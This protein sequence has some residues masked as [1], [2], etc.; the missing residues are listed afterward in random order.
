MPSLSMLQ[1][2]TI[3]IYALIYTDTYV[4][5]FVS[6]LRHQ[7]VVLAIWD[8]SLFGSHQSLFKEYVNSI[9]LYKLIFT[10]DKI[11]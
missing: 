3:H 7:A 5:V 1:H 4:H 9:L 10:S 11:Q 8:L 2:I 6:C